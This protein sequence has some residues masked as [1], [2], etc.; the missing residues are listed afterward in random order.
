MNTVYEVNGLTK[1]YDNQKKAND[2]ISLAIRQG[3]VVGVLGPNGAGKSTLIKQ[4]VGHVKPT[5][6]EIRL[7]GADVIKRSDLIPQYVGYYDQRPA[8]LDALTG[9]EAIYCTGRLR[10]MSRAAA[11][12][13]ADRLIELLNLGEVRKREIRK[14]SGGQQRMVGFATV[15]IGELPVLILDEPTN[16]LDP[17][18]RRQLWDTLA[19]KNRQEGTTILLVT[20]N[21]LEAEQVVDKVAVIDH[22][23]LLAYDSVGKLKQQVDSRLRLELTVRPEEGERLEALLSGYGTLQRPAANKIRLFMEEGRAGD[24]LQAVV[25]E[26]GDGC[27]EYR[28]VPPSLEDVY[29]KLGGKEGSI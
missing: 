1:I 25:S 27:E 8:A 29:F 2:N 28:V 26:A 18:R 11:K 12:G 10:G 14:M 16:E 7:F 4:M 9:Y 5:E 19:E 21:V 13:A 15:L 24:A 3:E 20:H 6:G 23:Q 17:E 22:G